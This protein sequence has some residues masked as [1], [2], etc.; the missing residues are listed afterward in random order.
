[1]ANNFHYILLLLFFSENRVEMVELNHFLWKWY[2]GVKQNSFVPDL[3]FYF[4]EDLN[5]CD[6]YN[7]INTLKAGGIPPPGP[8]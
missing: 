5:V 1:M 8:Q 7:I 3:L 2:S 6:V 4:Q